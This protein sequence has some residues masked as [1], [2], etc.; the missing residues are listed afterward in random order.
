MAKTV[1]VR[2]E[3]MVR[4]PSQS[5]LTLLGFGGFDREY[6]IEKVELISVMAAR[7]PPIQK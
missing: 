2:P 5:I 6:G 7:I 1:R 4:A 3:M